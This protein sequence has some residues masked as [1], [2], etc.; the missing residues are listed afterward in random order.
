MPENSQPKTAKELWDKIDRSMNFLKSYELDGTG[1]L[2]FNMMG[3][4]FELNLTAKEICFAEYE[5]DF[6]DYSFSDSTITISMP[7]WGELQTE[8][9]KETSIEAFHNGKMFISKES[10]ERT[11]KLYSSLTKEEYIAYSENKSSSTDDVNFNDC[12]NASFSRNDD[13]TWN[14]SYSGYTKKTMDQIVGSLE[15]DNDMLDLN[16]L[17]MEVTILADQQYRVKEMNIKFIFDEKN[18]EISAPSFELNSKYSNYNKATP[19]TDTLN[20]E[21]YTEIEDCR[22][23]F[24]LEDMIEDI[25]NKKDGSFVLELEQTLSIPSLNQTQIYTETDTVSYGEHN[26]QYFYDIQINSNDE[27]N[28]MKVSYANG[29]QTV[30]FSGKKESVSQSADEAKA[31][32]TELINTAGYSASYVSNIKN[33]GGGVY[34]IQC[35]QPDASI[36]ESIFIEYAGELTSIQQTLRITVKNGSIVKIENDTLAKGTASTGFS[37]IEMQV[38]LSSV[39]TFLP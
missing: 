10:S 36:Y 29:I 6:Y 11:Q 16:I 1:H 33:L 37:S 28:G 27:Y 13:G 4:K 24:D 20:P 12:V 25:E 17:D 38:H 32:I 14:L 7:S 3:A 9:M 22:L 35:D 26:G 19:I 5:N 34:E 39:N 21:D 15:M 8:T 31:L 30:D 18:G 23:I 2:S